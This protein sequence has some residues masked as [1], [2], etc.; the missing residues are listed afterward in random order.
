MQYML[1]L[2]ENGYI[3]PR[4]GSGIVCALS[5]I[6]LTLKNAAPNDVGLKAIKIAKK[7]AL[8]VVVM[9]IKPVNLD[10]YS[11]HQ[12]KSRRPRACAGGRLTE[13]NAE[14]HRILK[15]REASAKIAP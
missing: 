1:R 4:D 9:I 11:S 10:M 6:L 13:L 2:K 15:R 3:N 7:T 12:Q 14:V 8:G 5:T